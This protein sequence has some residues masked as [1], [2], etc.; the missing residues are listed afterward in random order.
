[1]PDHTPHN[2]VSRK[3]VLIFANPG[4]GARRNAEFVQHLNSALRQRDLDPVTEWRKEAWPALLADADLMRDCRC[5]VAAGGDGT[6]ADIVNLG[7]HVPLAVLPLGTEN[8]FARHFGFTRDI[9]RL[10]ATIAA[11]EPE[12]IDLGRIGDRDF[13]LLVS[14]GFDSAV[15]WRVGK[16]RSAGNSPRRVTY[17]A[18]LVPI[19]KTVLTYRFPAIDLEADG[20]LFSGVHAF[21]F[22]LPR[23]CLDLNVAPHANTHDGMLDWVIFKKP[24]LGGLLAYL[25]DIRS[26]RHLDRKDV[27]FGRARSIRI[28]SRESLPVQVDGDPSGHTPVDIGISPRRLA[29]MRP[30]PPGA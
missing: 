26:R 16:W 8:L 30:Q 18:Y 5:I 14:V 10:A 23:Y 19:L 28:S 27:Q 9:S 29:V 21:V 11:G 24:G 20:R 4:S 7:P 15:V 6:V 3:K 1:M 12:T 17:A 2:G 25:H 22:N 13:C